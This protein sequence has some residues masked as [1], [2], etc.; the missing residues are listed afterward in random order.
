MSLIRVG[1][2]DDGGIDLQG[3][4]WLPISQAGQDSSHSPSRYMRMR[5]LAQCKAEKKKIGPKYVRE[6]EGVLHRHATSMQ[7][8]A[9]HP[10]EAMQAGPI[11]GLLLSSSPFSKSAT[12]RAHSS[13]LPLCLLYVPEISSNLTLDDGVNP[14]DNEPPDDALGSIVFNPAL[15]GARGILQGEIEAR[16]EYPPVQGCIGRP[17]LWW[18][19]KQVPSWT[20][21]TYNP[22]LSISP[23]P[24]NH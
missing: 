17:G 22:D 20:P 5:V 12:L 8:I 23:I 11:V 1:G 7:H 16:W 13:P 3:W 10:T 6:M 24:N 15:G 9:N 19:G 4:W 21:D 2:K 14:A 18:Q